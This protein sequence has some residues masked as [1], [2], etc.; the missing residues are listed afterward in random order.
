MKILLIQYL[1]GFRSVRFTCKQVKQHVTYR[2][3]LGRKNS[4]SLNNF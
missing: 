3:F 1:E 4:R 2:W